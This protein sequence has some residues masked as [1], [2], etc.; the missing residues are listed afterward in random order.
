MNKKEKKRKDKKHT[1]THSHTET[2]KT[3]SEYISKI[4]RPKTKTKQQQPLPHLH[5]AKILQKYYCWAR[6]LSSGVVCVS[7]ETQLEKT[8]F[9]L[10][11]SNRFLKTHIQNFSLFML[12]STFILSKK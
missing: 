4:V 7:R 12:K 8:N 6:S 1:Q 10:V 9:S 2:I 3:K 5:P 11:N